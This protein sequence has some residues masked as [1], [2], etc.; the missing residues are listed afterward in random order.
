MLDFTQAKTQV[1]ETHQIFWMVSI[2][3]T[4]V[5]RFNPVVYEASK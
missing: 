4:Q 2:W 5:S 3:S 1:G